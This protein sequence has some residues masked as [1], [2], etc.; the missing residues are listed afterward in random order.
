[1]SLK[2]KSSRP[3]LT[4]LVGRFLAATHDSYLKKE[5]SETI[6]S[7]NGEPLISS[8]MQ[9][10]NGL[11]PVFCWHANKIHERAMGFSF[12]MGFKQDEQGVVGY[13]VEL[14]FATESTSE[15][16]L[17]LV[18]AFS[19]CMLALP[20]CSVVPNAVDISLLISAFQADMSQQFSLKNGNNFI[21]AKPAR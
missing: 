18:E 12:G 3:N 4:P 7:V 21:F 5:N 19:D 9:Y 2:T 13:D 11:L 15:I 17:Y 14:Q 16:L 8:D 6:F 10:S 1:M 20:K